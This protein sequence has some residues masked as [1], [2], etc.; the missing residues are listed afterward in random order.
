MRASRRAL[1]GGLAAALIAGPAAAQAVDPIRRVLFVGN[2]FLEE[3][4][5][6]ALVAARAAAAGRPIDVHAI[7]R[8]GAELAGHW[9]RRTVRETLSW[10]WEAA[11]LQDHSTAALDPDRARRSAAAVRA[12]AGALVG[13]PVILVVPWSRAP[14]HALYAEPGRPEG[15]EAMARANTEHHARLAAETGARLAPVATAWEGARAAGR[16]LHA[17]DGYHASG[18]GARL[19]ADVIWRALAPVLR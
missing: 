10:G 15:P 13:T 9:G 1:L 11:V 7:T 6:P 8:N 2:S 3:H 18:A 16:N 12:F 19:A 14:G 17:P 5:V 4:D